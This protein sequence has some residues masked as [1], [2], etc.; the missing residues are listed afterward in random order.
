MTPN[1]GDRSLASASESSPVESERPH[2][3]PGTLGQENKLDS[4]TIL[5]L[6]A[7]LGV[8]GLLLWAL[9]ELIPLR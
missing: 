3:S 9:L 8:M 1:G 7:V 5:L 4:A 2:P 6:A